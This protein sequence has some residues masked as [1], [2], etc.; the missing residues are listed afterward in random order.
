L[1]KLRRNSKWIKERQCKKL[2]RNSKRI[3]ERQCKKFERY[4]AVLRFSCFL[5]SLKY[6]LCA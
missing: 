4:F 2:R 5:T 3:K 6:L 1:I